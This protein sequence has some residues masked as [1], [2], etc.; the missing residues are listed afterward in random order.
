MSEPE[1][2]PE[3]S[4]SAESAATPEQAGNSA[5]AKPPAP[6][7]K[8]VLHIDGPP[9]FLRFVER[10]GQSKGWRVDSTSSESLG[11]HYALVRKYD[12]ILI[13]AHVPRVDP[14][15]LLRG[16]ARAKVVT[17]VFILTESL[18]KDEKL[19]GH[20]SNLRALIG[21]PLELKDFAAKLESKD[22]PV[23]ASLSEPVD[24]EKFLQ[25][26]ADW[27]GRKKSSPSPP[28]AVG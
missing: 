20:H 18:S 3:P 7:L 10:Y 11:F 8:H 15:R 24:K 22:R 4:S 21:K 6:P 2:A 26:V 12:Y 25:L 27:E 17:P 16:L 5:L 9:A 14:L 1:Q 23:A 13:G 28:A 19:F